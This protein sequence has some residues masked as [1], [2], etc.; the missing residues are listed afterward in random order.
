MGPHGQQAL[1]FAGN[2]LITEASDGDCPSIPDEAFLLWLHFGSE[3]QQ[4]GMHLPIRE[5]AGSCEIRHRMQ[6]RRADER[7]GGRRFDKVLQ[8]ARITVIRVDQHAAEM[9]GYGVT[10]DRFR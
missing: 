3:M 9:L 2:V 7:V 4:I 1:Y 5:R 10:E 8:V 6:R